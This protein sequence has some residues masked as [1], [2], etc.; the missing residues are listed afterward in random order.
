MVKLKRYCCLLLIMLV[1]ICSY[2]VDAQ[3]QSW[4]YAQPMIKSLD[5]QLENFASQ[6]YHSQTQVLISHASIRTRVLARDLLSSGIADP[7]EAG[8]TMVY[9][10]TMIFE[11]LESLDDLF[12]QLPDIKAI[13]EALLT[14][15][16]HQRRA[17]ALLKPAMERFSQN[18]INKI[19]LNVFHAQQVRLKVS[20]A[21]SPLADALDALRYPLSRN[22]WQLPSKSLLD[23]AQLDQLANRYQAVQAEADALPVLQ[24]LDQL[25]FA[26]KI[27]EFRPRV[28]QTY[29]MLLKTVRI[30]EVLHKQ[31]ASFLQARPLI[32]EQLKMGLSNYLNPKQRM[33]GQAQ[34][35]RVLVFEHLFMRI[36]QLLDQIQDTLPYEELIAK[37]IASEKD[38]HLQAVEYWAHIILDAWYQIRTKNHTQRD[39]YYPAFQMAAERWGRVRIELGKMTS[40][41][42][43][44]LPVALTAQ[45]QQ[46]LDECRQNRQMFVALN[47]LPL[48]MQH[49]LKDP[50][51][52]LQVIVKNLLAPPVLVEK[53]AATSVAEPLNENIQPQQPPAVEHLVALSDQWQQAVDINYFSPSD[54]AKNDPKGIRLQIAKDIGRW[55]EHWQQTEIAPKHAM[56]ELAPA[57][58]LIQSDQLLSAAVDAVK[59]GLFK[60]LGL[61]ALD[62]STSSQLVDLIPKYLAEVNRLYVD[63]KNI[64]ALKMNQQRLRQTLASLIA[65]GHLGG[66]Y[67]KN[68]PTPLNQK[69]SQLLSKLIWQPDSTEHDP[70]LSLLC[71]RFSLIGR[72]WCYQR[73]QDD[74]RH[75][76]E[77]FIQLNETGNKITARLSVLKEIAQ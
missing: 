63:H 66:H 33:H 47:R 2:T 42:A 14:P 56:Q 62:D 39:D 61:I 26:L 48:L 49:Q 31:D 50:F 21:F 65:L 76:R 54:I 25:R 15:T 19:R 46:W 17:Y 51:I 8:I 32:F 40:Q 73:Q 27:Q 22:T 20:E 16:E 30:L 9:Y 43:K 35:Y 11:N 7:S 60:R 37:S 52:P 55:L 6:K 5:Q 59:N 23:E 34:L 74:P 36:D 1:G 4:N 68:M 70:E 3:V 13:Q 38:A 64:Q 58:E 72:E 24:I 75:R 67:Q 57:Y 18:P 44:Q 10:G 45:H 77:L 12:T 41:I 71:A 28:C 29:Q 53:S 69:S